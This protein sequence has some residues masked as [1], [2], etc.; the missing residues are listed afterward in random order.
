MLAK[1]DDLT[2]N[3]EAYG[4]GKRLVLLHGWAANLH[5][6]ETLIPILSSVFQVIALDLPG[7]GH[8]QT[9][10]KTFGV[11]E[12]A[13]F[14]DKFLDYLDVKETF[15]LGHSM[16]GSVAIAYTLSFNRAKKLVLE[17][18]AGI[19]RK[20]LF[21]LAKIQFIETFKFLLLP[22]HRRYL[23]HIFGSADYRSAGAMRPTLVRMVN[24]DLS[25][26]LPEIKLPTLVIW[27]QNDTTTTLIEA[28]QINRRIPRSKL[29]ILPDCGHF[30]HL[31]RP[32]QFAEIVTNFLR[33]S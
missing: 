18:C 30:P 11:F 3:Y 17:D 24:E 4:Q 25:G 22:E 13:N 26:L 16:G 15:L 27:G 1:I 31:D 6:F 2:I 5:N 32:K 29:E 8:S 10:Q 9:P 28:K 14:L 20:G 23:K 21:T 7:F 19:R 12:Y 33:E